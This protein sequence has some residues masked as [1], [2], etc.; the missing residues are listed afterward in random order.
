[1][2]ES[3]P[4]HNAPP[5][6]TWYRFGCDNKTDNRWPNGTF[7]VSYDKSDKII[8]FNYVHTYII[9]CYIVHTMVSSPTPMQWLNMVHISYTI[10]IIK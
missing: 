1:M 8:N 9:T 7:P 3:A 4:E 10:M 5:F 6:D 2:Y